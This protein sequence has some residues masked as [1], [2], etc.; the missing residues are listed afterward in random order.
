M[1]DKAVFDSITNLLS[2]ADDARRG[3][4]PNADEFGAIHVI[5]FGDFKQRSRII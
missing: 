1:M 3:A 5:L 2:T 4:A